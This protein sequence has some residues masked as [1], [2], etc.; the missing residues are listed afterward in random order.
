MTLQNIAVFC[1]SFS[2]NHPLFV[3]DTQ[4]LAPAFKHHHINLIYGGG[5]TGLMNALA[6]AMLQH[7][8]MVTGVMPSFMTPLELVHPKLTQLIEVADFASRKQE[9][10]ALS[11]G[12][13]AL[14]GGLGTLDE[15]FEVWTQSTVGQCSKPIALLNTQGFFDGLI[16]FIKHQVTCGFIPPCL[17]EHLIVEADPFQMITRMK[18]QTVFPNKLEKATQ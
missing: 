14:P 8:V 9:I 5:N 12:F 1:G 18:N 3:Q 11:D 13:I 10:M 4:S 6:D 17:F 15:L 7:Q 16:D 2:G